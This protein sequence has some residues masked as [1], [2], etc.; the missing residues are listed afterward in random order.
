M[1]SNEFSL[2][3]EDECTIW[4]VFDRN[5][6]IARLK[7]VLWA[8]GWPTG[9]LKPHTD[10]CGFG[11][12]LVIILLVWCN[13]NT[14]TVQPH[15]ERV[16]RE[17]GVLWYLMLTEGIQ[18]N[19]KCKGTMLW[20]SSYE[21]VCCLMLA[22]LLLLANSSSFFSSQIEERKTLLAWRSSVRCSSLFN[23]RNCGSNFCI[24]FTMH[25]VMISAQMLLISKRCKMFGEEMFKGL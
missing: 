8:C 11:E 25:G 4:N 21:R 1:I 23:D 24:W 22:L 10:C 7:N 13:S 18:N 14:K 17:T 9:C 15:K 5:G 16:K 19:A 2:H 12:I 20:K 3:K 6:M